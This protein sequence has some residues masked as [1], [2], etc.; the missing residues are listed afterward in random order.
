MELASRCHAVAPNLV[1][2]N[3]YGPTEI[4]MTCCAH[5]VPQ[6]QAAL[7]PALRTGPDWGG[8]LAARE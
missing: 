8:R 4:T 5:D 7:D 2:V 6:R 1:V 3:H